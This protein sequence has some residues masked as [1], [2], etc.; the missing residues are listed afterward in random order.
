MYFLNSLTNF[1]IK[2]T[3][4]CWKTVV[5]NCYNRTPE[6]KSIKNTKYLIIIGATNWR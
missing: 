5:E 1:K 2:K 6:Q 3:K 4:K